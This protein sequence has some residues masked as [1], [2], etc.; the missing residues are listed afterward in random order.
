M[1]RKRTMRQTFHNESEGVAKNEDGTIRV[2]AYC[3]VSV[4][5]IRKRSILYLLS[6]YI[7][8]FARLWDIGLFRGCVTFGS[9][10]S[11]GLTEWLVFSYS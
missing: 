3:R 2:A 6:Y 5:R 8:T 7:K 4:S 10:G 1:K 9:S 11:N